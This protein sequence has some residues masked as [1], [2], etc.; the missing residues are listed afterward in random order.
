MNDSMQWMIARMLEQHG[1]YDL[2]NGFGITHNRLGWCMYRNGWH[3]D[4]HIAKLLGKDEP[5]DDELTA[6]ATAVDAIRDFGRVRAVLGV[7]REAA[8]E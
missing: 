3:V 1:H 5:K 7:K 4:L 8:I 2:H 6:Y